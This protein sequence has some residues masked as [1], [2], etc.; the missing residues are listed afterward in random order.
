[1]LRVDLLANLLNAGLYLLLL[2]SPRPSQN[3]EKTLDHPDQACAA[4]HQEIYDRY[5]RTPMAQGSGL[6]MD[7]LIV[8]D[9][10]HA[11]SGVHYN[12]SERNGE[13][14]LSYERDTK[15][16]QAALRGEQRL[17]YFIGSGRRGR[18]YLFEQEGWWFEAPVNFYGKKQVWD[19]APAFGSARNMPS[20]LAVDSNCLHC[21]A[22]QVQNAM[23]EARNR[24]AD[25]PFRQ[26]GV[27]CAACHGDPAVHL[28]TMSNHKQSSAVRSILN[29][30]TLTPT[31]R[32]AVCLQCHLEG[33]V[34]VY[35]PGKSLATFAPGDELSEHAVHFVDSVRNPREGR[36]TSQ[37]EA[38][39]QSACKRASGDKLTCTTCHDP[40]GSPAPSERVAFYRARCLTC[41]AGT[42]FAEQHHPE[43]KD[44]ASCH[45]PRRQTGDIAHEQLT[46]HNIQSRPRNLHLDSL[47]TIPHDSA[48]LVSVG[49][50]PY[51]DRELGIAY[52]QLARQG[53]RQSGGKA[54]RLLHNTEVAGKADIEVHLQLGFLE[55]ESGNTAAARQE[56]LAVL[57]K[58]PHQQI[59][60][61]D[62]AVIEAATGNIPDA[63]RL[64][65]QVVAEDPGQTAA[66]LNLAWIECRLGHSQEA[67]QVVQ[68]M[69]VFNP[70]SPDGSQFLDKGMYQNQHCSL[71]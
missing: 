59:A 40:H 43:E 27:G 22:S 50:E 15:T 48:K 8:G 32:D 14:W 69:L 60:A 21:H 10:T 38:L 33:D 68:R 67:R 4:C 36:A 18:T 41:H 44:C 37:F 55:Q 29:P 12:I 46:D 42:Q 1:V 64:L 62:L 3:A 35:L 71:K 63:I 53:D 57:A 39:L 9:F 16:E 66:G 25:A 61:A 19:M 11:T 6:A 17:D 47:D 30:T 70:D 51:T 13:A 65:K 20:T 2:W 7:G 5:Q 34:T 49:G 58:D 24:Y 28:N 26:G 45:M 54:L 31:R 23:P 56:Y 52:A